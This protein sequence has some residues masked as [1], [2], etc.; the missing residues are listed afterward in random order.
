LSVVASGFRNVVSR[1]CFVSASSD[2]SVTSPSTRAAV[3]L[4][5]RKLRAPYVRAYMRE[6][7]SRDSLLDQS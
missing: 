5:C 6:T 3:T 4:H 7:A 2:R 1:C